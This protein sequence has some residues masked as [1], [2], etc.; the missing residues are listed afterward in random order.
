MHAALRT[1]LLS[2]KMGV[3]YADETKAIIAA[4]STP[5]TSIRARQINDAVLGFKTAAAL[6]KLDLLYMPVANDLQ[7]GSLN[8]VAPSTYALTSN[9]APVFTKDAGIAT[10][11]AGYFDTGFNPS[12]AAGRKYALNDM[13]LAV[14]FV[15]ASSG[16]NAI[17][18]NANAR[19]APASAGNLTTRANDGTTKTNPNAS[20]GL[21]MVTRLSS[22][23]YRVRLWVAGVKTIDQIVTQA[24]S[25]I[26]NVTFKLLS[27]DGATFNPNTLSFFAAGAALNDSQGDAVAAAYFTYLAAVTPSVRFISRVV[28]PLDSNG[29]YIVCTGGVID[30]EDGTYWIGND[31]RASEASSTYLSSVEHLSADK[32]TRLSSVLMSGQGVATQDSVQG[33]AE[34]TLLKTMWCASFANGG[35]LVNFSKAGANISIKTP[36]FKAN[37]LAYDAARDQLVIGAAGTNTNPLQVSWVNKST[38]A[39]VSTINVANNPDHLW[40]S[41]DGAYLWYTWGG[42]GPAGRLVRR[43]LT[44]GEELTY[45][46]GTTGTQTAADAVEGA[47]LYFVGGQLRADICNDARFHAG[48]TTEN[49]IITYE[50]NQS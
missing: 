45:T 32:A 33:V 39:E 18:G 9:G 46:L 31:G 29:Q 23:E 16:V 11:T 40:M 50:L 6:A 15:T 28:L 4:M 48:A 43:D 22:T 37:G 5:P 20:P 21:A 24:S 14:G 44:T 8:W 35:R 30:S 42:N 19:I 26:S 3:G 25:S 1:A 13:T 27:P 10:G 36:P 17:G 49:A 41:A 7:A 47:M 2:P 12:S 34:D 38:M